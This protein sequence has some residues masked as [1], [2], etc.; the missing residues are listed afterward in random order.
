MGFDG[1]ACDMSRYFKDVNEAVAVLV[2]TTVAIWFV[3]LDIRMA[4]SA[5]LCIL[6][7]QLWKSQ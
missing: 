3:D 2:G 7:Y 4:C 1:M 6:P 5:L